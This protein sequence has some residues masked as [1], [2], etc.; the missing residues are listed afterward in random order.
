MFAL[1]GY[2]SAADFFI[3]IYDGLAKQ[4]KENAQDADGLYDEAKRTFVGF[5]LQEQT[6]YILSPQ[7]DMFNVGPRFLTEV[8]GEVAEPFCFDINKGLVGRYLPYKWSRKK[9]LELSSF[10]LF[11]GFFAYF[12]FSYDLKG[13]ESLVRWVAALIL[14]VFIFAAISV[15]LFW[16]FKSQGKTAMQVFGSHQNSLL[17][18]WRGFS[19]VFETKLVEAYLAAEVWNQSDVE[20]A[21]ATL[22]EA[23]VAKEIISAHRA[24]KLSTKQA[25]SAKKTAQ[26][27][28][29]RSFMRAWD[30]ARETVPEIGQPGRKPNR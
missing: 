4:R 1:D 9:F 10:F 15:T 8:E 21:G 19:V 30:K 25:M 22:A 7:G 13:G 26:G 29:V 17:S 12:T 14:P 20:S 11:T 6:G 24:G 2:T 3:M 28:S 18:D 23:A 27:M 5:L 16:V